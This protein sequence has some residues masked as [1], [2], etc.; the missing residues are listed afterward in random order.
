MVW[1]INSCKKSYCF[2]TIVTANCLFKRCLSQSCLFTFETFC[3]AWHPVAVS[4]TKVIKILC[5][6]MIVEVFLHHQNGHISLLKRIM[7][8]ISFH[9]RLRIT[10]IFLISCVCLIYQYRIPSKK[11]LVRMFAV[12]FAHSFHHMRIR[13]VERA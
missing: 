2:I 9:K 8:L 7:L 3:A 12:C 1:V 13:G 11:I 5:N 6:E 4:S 10:F